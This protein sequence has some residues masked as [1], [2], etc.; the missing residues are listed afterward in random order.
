MEPH[1]PK[2]APIQRQLMN[3]MLLTSGSVLALTCLA[4]FVYEYFTFR[5]TLKN[6][7][8][9]LGEIIAANSTAALAFDDPD[10]AEELLS[11][12]RTNRHIVAAC[13]YDKE[14][15]IFARYPA[16]APADQFP[17]YLP[18]RN[19]RFSGSYLEG[20]QP[21]VQGRTQLGSLY[22]KSDMEAMFERFSR[23]ALIA[24]TVVGVMLGLAYL[25][26]R[27]LQRRI[28]RPILALAQTAGQ[29]SR[30]HNYSVRA[31]KYQ[32]D[33]VG[34]L[35]DAF[36]LMLTQIDRQNSE[37]LAMNQQLEERIKARTQELEKTND[38]LT[39]V[40][41][42]LVKSNR[43]LEQFANVAS[44]DLQEPLRKIQMF[45]QLVENS[46]DDPSLA[47]EYT[48]KIKNA[49]NRMTTLIKSVLNYSRL[50]NHSEPF[51]PIDLNEVI[52]QIQADFE[53][54]ITE[55]NA[56]V[57]A[58]DLPVIQG[59]PLQ[60]NQLFSNLIG[61]AL[62]FCD[63]TPQ[64]VITA[65]VHEPGRSRLPEELT[66]GRGY[67]ELMVEDNGIGFDTSYSRKIFTIFQ[68]LHT[69]KEY[70]GTGIGL[71]LCKRIVENHAGTITVESEVGRGTRFY[72]YLPMN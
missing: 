36:N 66:E 42:K 43:D 64:I 65:R 16:D 68:R 40:N 47:R 51:I 2:A 59:I 39:V 6:Q 50:S 56:T 5:E 17:S 49:A 61:N 63:K 45:A 23:Y 33:E 11:A 60:I 7:L 9:M 15:R 32:E 71:A 58:R 13:L 3:V 72:V 46:I 52:G 38:E 41:G 27:R 31:T 4:F 10:D 44:H 25:L 12:L 19:Y 28:S 34:L 29:V 18:A 55:K 26:S 37:I 14:G 22:L 70:P 67:A 54:L 62:K 35:T 57:T 20:F 53:L 21:V 1:K 24:A 69:Q 8:T 30:D 48:D